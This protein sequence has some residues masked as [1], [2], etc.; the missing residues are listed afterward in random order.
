[1]IPTSDT[2]NPFPSFRRVGVA[3][4]YS[5]V[6]VDAKDT[7][8]KVA[9]GGWL[10]VQ[11]VGDVGD[12][13]DNV[14]APSAKYA[15]Y[16]P[17]LWRLDG[18][19][20]I[21]PDSQKNVATG[22]WW[23]DLSDKN[24]DF[25]PKIVNY[26]NYGKPAMQYTFSS[27]ISTVGWSFFFDP[28]IGEYPTSVEAVC[29]DA[30]GA[31]IDTHEFACEAATAYIPHEVAEYTKVTFTFNSWSKPFRRVRLMEIDFGL[32][33][34]WDADRVGEVRLVGGM[35]PTA[36]AFP[37]RQ[38]TFTFDNSKKVFDLLDP[39]GIYRFLQEGQTIETSL[40]IG[41]E[42]VFMGDFTF[43]DVSIGTS[44]L[45]PTIQG[46]D[47]VMRLDGEMCAKGDDGTCTLET[48]VTWALGG[49]DATVR[50]AEGVAPRIVRKSIGE[51]TSKRE[52][53]R[54]FAQAARCTVYT[55]RY[56][57]ICFAPPVI[58]D[59]V[60]EITADE[61]YSYSGVSVEAVVDAVE[62]SSSPL[63][64][65]AQTYTSGNGKKKKTISNPCVA[66]SAGQ[67]V[68]D[69]ILAVSNWR[70]KYS[71][72]NRCDPAIDIGD[73]IRIDDI[74]HHMGKAVVTEYT[75]TFNGGLSTITG[76]VG[77]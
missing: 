6:D 63:E 13:F 75:T 20:S 34:V 50:Y 72:Q 35:S 65:D 54:M 11:K 46:D 4:K 38:V 76:A 36:D 7:V 2:Y 47:I 41:G 74:Y 21:L 31:E 52:A 57:V 23:G 27:P 69:W 19:F 56:G 67:A 62:V 22:L 16:E 64:G 49:T 9:A 66:P 30:D 29:Y 17:N 12:T 33:E 51:N 43:S 70:K 44:V 39:Q 68:A 59:V 55:D 26:V 60:G 3:L 61:L 28:T 53:L 18:S 40:V 48:A 71:V 42:H 24:G 37:S 14:Y 8:S 73:T 5:I 77:E 1:M 45:T 32:T 25:Q 15:S 58:G 10:G